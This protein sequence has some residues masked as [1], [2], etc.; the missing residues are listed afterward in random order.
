MRTSSRQTSGECCRCNCDTDMFDVAYVARLMAL[1]YRLRAR[2]DRR[3]IWKEAVVRGRCWPNDLDINWHMNNARYLREADFGRF[4]L[5]IETG[6]WDVLKHRRETT[7]KDANILV[8]ALQVQYRQS[9]RLADRFEV[10][11]RINGWDENAF[12][13]EQSINCTRTDRVACSFL[14]RLAVTPRTL[15]PQMLADDLTSGLCSSPALSPAML[16]FKNNHR[17]TW[18]P[19]RTAE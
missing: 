5:F 3:N 10:R 12:Y 16:R 9:L 8:S 17:L 13:S 2:G 11:S 15:T 14:V 18:S 6:L 19:T 7:T 4:C 1:L